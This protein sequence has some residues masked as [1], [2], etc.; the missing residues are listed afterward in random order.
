MLSTAEHFTYGIEWRLFTHVADSSGL[1]F[2]MSIEDHQFIKTDVQDWRFSQCCRWG[3][4]SSVIWRCFVASSVC[5]ILKDCSTF[6][7]WVKTCLTRLLAL[8]VAL[9]SFGTS[10]AN[11]TNNIA[12][13]AAR[14]ESSLKSN[15]PHYHFMVLGWMLTYF[16]TGLLLPL[17]SLCPFRW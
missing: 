4:V 1:G 6:I 3:R 5:D 10:G 14:L 15:L 8:M 7:N 16:A 17:W 13:P 2:G 12:L 11:L 9:W